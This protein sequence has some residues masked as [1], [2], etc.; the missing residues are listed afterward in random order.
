[1]KKQNYIKKEGN[2]WSIANPP[3]RFTVIETKRKRIRVYE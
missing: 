1:M 2:L 3:R